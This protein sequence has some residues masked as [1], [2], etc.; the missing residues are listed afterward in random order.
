VSPTNGTTEYPN[1]VT[2]TVSLT[3]NDSAACQTTTFSLASDALF[4]GQSTNEVAATLGN[5]GLTVAPGATATTSIV[6]TPLVLPAQSKSYS[7]RASAS[8]AVQPGAAQGTVGLTVTPPPV[9][10]PPPSSNSCVQSITGCNASGGNTCTLSTAQNYEIT[11]EFGRCTS[12]GGSSGGKGRV[13]R[14]PETTDA[15]STGRGRRR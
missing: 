7:V 15:T 2:Y 5:S 6:A 1:P 13:K 12:V 10:P 4:S 9:V 8:R 14:L 3:N 11:V